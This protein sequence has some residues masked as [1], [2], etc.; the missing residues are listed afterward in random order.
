METKSIINVGV[1]G[2][3]NFGLFALQQLAQV[4]DVRIVAMAGTFREAAL[5]LG[6]RFDI[7]HLNSVDELLRYPEINLVYI[8]TPPFLHYEQSMMGLKSGKH[9]ICEKPMALSI[10]EAK[11]MI[12]LA[13][14]NNLLMVTHLMQRYNPLYE[15]IR[16]LIIQKPLGEL[17]H[18]FFENY[19]ADEGLS[20]QHWFWDKDKSGGI[21]IEHGVHFFDLFEGWLGKGTVMAAQRGRRPGTMFEE[22]VQC[23]VKYGAS[24]YINYYH[25]FHQPARMDRQEMRLVFE[26]GDVTLYEWIPTKMKMT[27]LVNEEETKAIMNIFPGG[28]LKVAANYGAEDRLCIGRHKSLDVYQLVNITYGYENQKMHLYS[29]LVRSFFEDQLT[30]IRDHGHERKITE[31]NGLSSLEVA[32]KANDMATE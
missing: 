15:K 1:I 5:A 27:A 25:G 18:G 13:K 12:S 4:P 28:C 17:L 26:R 31:S 21:F 22:Q 2:G 30:W 3:G 9:V 23:V 10:K 19:A 8:S 24:V 20:P 7:K 11:E 32:V 14:E 16:Q 29:D 6:R